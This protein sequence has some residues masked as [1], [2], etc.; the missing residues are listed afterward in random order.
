MGQPVVASVVVN[1][2]NYG[3]FLGAAIDSALSQTHPATEVVVVDDGSTDSSRDVIARYGSRVTAVLK[4]N[5][6]QGSAFNAGLQA[7]RGSVVV[8][9]DADDLLLPTAVARACDRLSEPD[10]HKVHWPL[11]VIDA[12]GQRTGRMWPAAKL[13]DGDFRAELAARGPACIASPPTSGNAWARQFLERVM[14]IPQGYGLCADEYLYT[15]APAWGIVRRIEEPQGCYRLHGANHYQS[16]S[17]E[18]RIPIG[19]RVQERQC[20]LLA[21]H[22]RREG[23][24][25]DSEGWLAQTWFSRL[26]RAIEQVFSVIPEGSMFILIDDTQWGAGSTLGGR[27]VLPF[28]ERNG[29]YWGPPAN[30]AAGIAE[31]ERLRAAGASYLIVVQAAFWWFDHYASFTKYLRARFRLCSASELVIEFDLRSE[32]DEP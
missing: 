28:I 3:R 30:D 27:R 12:S 6:G 21:D 31:V 24:H 18:Q 17:L 9:L 19:A 5:G 11:W 25:V 26:Q 15:L 23:I 10:V 7:S 22:L 13:P 16:L 29:T 20:E 2:Y 1:N 32:A 14:P 4:E 8:F